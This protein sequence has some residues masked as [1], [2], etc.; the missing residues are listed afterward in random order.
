M[1]KGVEFYYDFSIP[2]SYRASTKIEGICAKYGAE[3]DWKPF[4]IGSVYKETGNRAP[5]GVP[6]KK[7]YMMHDA[8]Y[9]MQDA[10]YRIHDA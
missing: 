8:G 10:R 2:Y 4:L 7:R 1:S 9:K 6:S 5:L 3:L